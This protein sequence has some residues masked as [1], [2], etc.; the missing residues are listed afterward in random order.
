MEPPPITG[1][2]PIVTTGWSETAPRWMSGPAYA[3]S[4]FILRCGT[5]GND[6]CSYYGLKDYLSPQSPDSFSNARTP[7]PEWSRANQHGTNKR[8]IAS[9]EPG[10]TPTWKHVE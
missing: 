8:A 10:E 6:F 3:D 4:L 2:G 5:K 9:V 7:A 1:V